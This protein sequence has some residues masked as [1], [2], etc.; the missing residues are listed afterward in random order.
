MKRKGIDPALPLPK[1]QEATGL[2]RVTLWRMVRAGTFP[3]PIYL[4]ERK[5]GWRESEVVKWLE[6]RPKV[7]YPPRPAA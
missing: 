2:G 5:I 1:V 6:A 4:T 3:A 7:Q